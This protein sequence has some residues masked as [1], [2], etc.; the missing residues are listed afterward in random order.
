MQ[1]PQAIQLTGTLHEN[2]RD[3]NGTSWPYSKASNTAAYDQATA[4]AK[5]QTNATRY[6]DTGNRQLVRVWSR[7]LRSVKTDWIRLYRY[8]FPVRNWNLAARTSTPI[9]RSKPNDHGVSL[10]KPTWIK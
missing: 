4:A 7:V 2:G 6:C 9:V 8:R 3:D 10:L 1:Q 5:T